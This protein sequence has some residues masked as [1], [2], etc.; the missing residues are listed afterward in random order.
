MSIETSV[1]LK[2]KSDL[3]AE[4]YNTEGVEGFGVG[5]DRLRVYIANEAVRNHLP[6]EYQCIPIEFVV[7]G[8]IR[9][10]G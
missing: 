3:K 8:K 9:L 4:F 6:T 2:A 10:Y 7:T 1:L 5:K